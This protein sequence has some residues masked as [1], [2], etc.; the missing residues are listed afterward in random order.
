MKPEVL[1][2]ALREAPGY[3]F[4][5]VSTRFDEYFEG[6]AGEMNVV[7]RA[8]LNT[9]S[10]GLANSFH[11]F[12]HGSGAGSWRAGVY[13]DHPGAARQ[14][15][16]GTTKATTR[17][18]LAIP[19]DAALTQAGDTKADPELF[20]RERTF[21]QES[22]D[23]RVFIFLKTGRKRPSGWKAGQPDPSVVPLFRLKKTAG[24]IEGRLGFFRAWDDESEDRDS[25]LEEAA[26]AAL[27]RVGS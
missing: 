7:A 1:A 9:R 8:N 26:E 2:K 12:A 21:V 13:T 18:Y 11:H 5:E 3:L 17:R 27:E 10:G 20:G 16:G 14:E 24:P 4:E 6:F 25:L 19:L 23:G 22:R 15:F